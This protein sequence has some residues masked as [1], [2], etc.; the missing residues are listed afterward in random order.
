MAR[1]NL[2]ARAR[3]R[4]VSL[5]KLP[6]AHESVLSAVSGVDIEPEDFSGGMG[7][8]PISVSYPSPIPVRRAVLAPSLIKA[9]FRPYTPRIST[10]QALAA[11][12]RVV[13]CV[14]RK[15][16]RE[17]LFAKRL[18]GRNGGGKPY[19]RTYSSQWSC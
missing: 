6:L 17:V 3:S 15:Q 19:R 14:R 11:N 18:N 16:R 2:N 9:Q 8:S 5:A 7:R 1:S 13:F 4:R 12:P 10:L